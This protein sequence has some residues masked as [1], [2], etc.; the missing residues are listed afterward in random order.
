MVKLKNRVKTLVSKLRRRG[1]KNV[2]PKRKGGPPPRPNMYPSLPMKLTTLPPKTKAAVITYLDHKI[3]R[4]QNELGKLTG[5][6]VVRNDTGRQMTKQVPIDTF[7]REFSIGGLPWQNRAAKL[8]KEVDY[9][10]WQ[11]SEW[12]SARTNAPGVSSAPQLLP[13]VPERIFTRLAYEA[14]RNASRNTKKTSP[15]TPATPA[16]TSKASRVSTPMGMALVSVPMLPSPAAATNGANGGRHTFFP[17]QMNY[18]SARALYRKLVLQLHPNKGGNA[19]TFQRVMRQYEIYM[20]QRNLHR[21]YE[22]GVQL[23]RLKPTKQMPLDKILNEGSAIVLS[24]TFHSIQLGLPTDK[25]DALRIEQVL[26]ARMYGV[27]TYT[28]RM[29][30]IMAKIDAITEPD[31]RSGRGKALTVK[32]VLK[33]LMG[34]KKEAYIPTLQGKI[35]RLNKIIESVKRVKPTFILKRNGK[36]V[37]VDQVYLDALLTDLHAMKLVTE[38]ALVDARKALKKK[39]NRNMQKMIKDGQAAKDDLMRW[40]RSTQTRTTKG[41]NNPIYRGQYGRLMM[42]TPPLE[43]MIQSLVPGGSLTDGAAIDYTASQQTGGQRGVVS[44]NLGQFY[45]NGVQPQVSV[46]DTAY[47]Y[48]SGVTSLIALGLLAR[49]RG[50]LQI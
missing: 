10:Q 23:L 19:N 22:K 5:T 8:Q 4:V 24:G 36:Q 32:S 30:S 39:T 40:M 11:R 28:R 37:L 25:F 6:V 31:K 21:E 18:N 26:Y 17:E 42:S 34:M 45:F 43:F 29:A 1:N 3:E 7:A 41:K 48:A 13:Q 38:T 12:K 16:K 2:T 46:L 50:R 20:T 15:T 49:I 27:K 14:G 35:R 33:Q 9:L 47:S 44:A